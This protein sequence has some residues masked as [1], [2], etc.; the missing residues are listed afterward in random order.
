M[1]SVPILEGVAF[2]LILRKP[3]EK[4]NATVDTLNVGQTDNA[5]YEGHS[6][7]KLSATDA[8]DN[9][10]DIELNNECDTS[11]GLKEK[12]LYLPSLLKYIIPITL[13]YFLEYFINQGLV[14]SSNVL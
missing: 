12:I 8:I 10:K 3:S 5:A 9:T 2:W 4:S 6:T 14:S 11:F 13:V 1:L 7:D